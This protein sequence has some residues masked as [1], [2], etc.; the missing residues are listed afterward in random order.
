[1]TQPPES[2]SQTAPA[3]HSQAERNLESVSDANVS[4]PLLKAVAHEMWTSA[5]A[6]FRPGQLVA[7]RFRIVRFV[8]R[9]G[10]GE[11]YEADDLRLRERVALK[12]IRSNIA[13][14]PAAMGRFE[15][16]LRLARKV[17]HPNVCRIFDI[18]V[19][20]PAEAGGQKPVV[21]LSM[22]LLSGETLSER[23][24]RAGRFSEAEALPLVRQMAAALSAAHE[25]G[26]IHRD[27]KSQNVMLCGSGERLRAVV[28]DFGLAQESFVRESG[29]TSVT[30]AARSPSPRRA[31]SRPSRRASRSGS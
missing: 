28:T 21:F 22:E 1:V 19:A 11:L 29:V 13:G 16:E 14:D 25:A 31:A 18:E 30:G 8:A 12:A 17:T 4:D 9:G 23:L 6:S 15:R 24:K 20:E 3:R 26:V 27:F 10:M 7:E 5:E 2:G